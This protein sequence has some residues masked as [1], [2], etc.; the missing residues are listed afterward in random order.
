[1]KNKTLQKSISIKFQKTT[2]VVKNTGKPVEILL[3]GYVDETKPNRMS[4]SMFIKL[5][6]DAI[7]A[8]EPVRITQ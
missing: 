3:C 4:S 2:L 8:V 1:M 6:Y 5:I 7:K